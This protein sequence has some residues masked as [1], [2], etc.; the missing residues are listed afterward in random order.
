[1]DARSTCSPPNVGTTPAGS[2][3]RS[4]G[5]RIRVA[6]FADRRHRFGRD[7]HFDRDDVLEGVGFAGQLDRHPHARAADR[8]ARPR[9]SGPRP[10]RR[11]ARRSSAAPRSANCR[12]AGSR[13]SIVTVAGPAVFNWL[14]TTAPNDALSPTARK[15]GNVAFSVTRLVDPDLAVGR[16]ETRAAVAGHRHDPVGRQRLGQLHVHAS[17]GRARRS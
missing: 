16:S 17:R 11:A 15:R 14:V 1:M 10:I 12:T 2:F 13:L 8:P 5:R 7:E 4:D 6:R 9:R 3:R